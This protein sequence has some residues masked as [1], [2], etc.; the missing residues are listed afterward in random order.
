MNLRCI[1]AGHRAAPGEVRNQGFGFSR[2]GRCRRD[3]V[4]SGRR[5]RPVPKGFRVAWK[6]ADHPMKTGAGPLL[7]DLPAT[8]RTLTVAPSGGRSSAAY[9]MLLA[10]LGCRYLFWTFR[11]RIASWRRRTFSARRPRAR[12]IYLPAFAPA[13]S[14]VRGS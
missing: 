7:P 8:G 5:W 13:Q 6:K 10:A 1:M 12:T 4:R 3:M 11:D 14:G 9:V 2:C